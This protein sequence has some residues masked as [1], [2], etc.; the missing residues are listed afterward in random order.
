[1]SHV[2]PDIRNYLIGK[3]TVSIMLSGDSAWRDMGNC[4]T[5]EFTPNLTKLEHFSS[6]SGVKKKDRVVVTEKTGS[7][8]VVMEEWTAQNLALALMG[9]VSTNSAAQQEIDIFSENTITAKVKFTGT[10]E[11][12]PKWE[13]T[14]NAVDFIPSAALNPISD[15]WGQ[16]EVTGDVL[17][18]NTGS[19]GKAVEIAVE[20]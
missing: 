4:P 14:F 12:G 10:N 5:F 7:L 19:F 3:G 20:V 6:R 13:Y 2:S 17:A 11:V 15:Q 8:K 16:I 1:M 18:D 9:A